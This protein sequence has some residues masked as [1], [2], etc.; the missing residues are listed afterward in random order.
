MNTDI[1][2]RIER[3]ELASVLPPGGLTLVSG[4][5]AESSL[6][7]AM[8]ASTGESL[9]DMTFC[10]VFVVGLNRL[11]WR[12]GP[13]SRVI[14]FFLTPELR[15]N[16]DRVD[17]L[18]LCY[19]DALAELRRRRP[20][21]AL[22]MCAPPDTAGNCSFG[23]DVSF[24]AEL[25]RDIPI[26]IAHVNR[27]MP[28]TAGDPGIPFDQLTAFI[29]AE[30]P[31][32]ALASVGS[33]PV[34]NAIAARVAPFVRDGDTVQTGLGHVPDAVARGLRDRR[35]LKVH[36]GL[37]G[38]G[39]MDL[40]DSGAVDNA[41][42]GTAIGS[43]ELYSR[44][45]HPAIEFRPVSITHGPRV[46]AAIDRFVSINS[47]LAVD[48]FGQA[49]SEMGGNGLTS[50]PGGASDYARGARAGVGTRIIVL[51]ATTSSTSRIVAPGQMPGPVSLSRFDTDLVVTEH[52]A[53]D[54]R[55]LGHAVRA[56]ALIDIAD[57]A[58]RDAL[59]NAWTAYANAF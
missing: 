43:P 21:A 11:T 52:G 2:R 53:A 25:W 46:L 23:T 45:S 19:Q 28:A 58:H 30:H 35:N 1:P 48:L 12:A 7:A 15:A 5:S 34:A 18:P 41:I 13:D 9:G 51:P 26:R 59:R 38:D 22:F 49:F 29:E 33:T 27:M 39:L 36:G 20:T 55:G 6:L 17:F 37:L 14:T 50:G 32:L 4:C 56:K 31:L 57:P 3:H 44:L 10:G 47:A 8:V 40:I 24:I 54:L 16:G 42:V